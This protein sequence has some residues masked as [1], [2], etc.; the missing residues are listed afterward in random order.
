MNS[1]LIYSLDHTYGNF[2]EYHAGDNPAD[3][4]HKA[5]EMGDVNQMA[6]ILARDPE[7][8]NRLHSVHGTSPLC[9]AIGNYRDPTALDFLIRYQADPLTALNTAS[10]HY[11]LAFLTLVQK[12]LQTPLHQLLLNYVEGWIGLLLPQM[13]SLSTNFLIAIYHNVLLLI[14]HDIRNDYLFESLP[15]LKEL[16]MQRD[17]TSDQREVISLS[18]MLAETAHLPFDFSGLSNDSC[19]S[20]INQFSAHIKDDEL[21]CELVLYANR[22]MEDEDQSFDLSPYY[23]LALKLMNGSN[24][25]FKASIHLNKSIYHATC[26]HLSESDSDSLDMDSGSDDEKSTDELL[27]NH[28]NFNIQR[29]I[30]ILNSLAFKN[31]TLAML[32]RTTVA[33]TFRLLVENTRDIE[34]ILELLKL[35]QNFEM[36]RFALQEIQ[37]ITAMFKAKNALLNDDQTELG[38]HLNHIIYLQRSLSDIDRPLAAFHSDIMEAAL[39]VIGQEI[40]GMLAMQVFVENIHNEVFNALNNFV[41]CVVIMDYYDL[42]AFPILDYLSK[43]SL[44]FKTLYYFKNEILTN[45][46]ALIMY[47]SYFDQALQH[48]S[49]STKKY[50]T[51]LAMITAAFNIFKSQSMDQH[52]PRYEAALINALRASDYSLFTA[53]LQEIIPMLAND[54]DSS[55]MSPL[56]NTLAEHF[57]RFRKTPSKL[58]IELF[59]NNFIVARDIVTHPWLASIYY[60][61]IEKVIAEQAAAARMPENSSN[62]LC[63]LIAENLSTRMD[64]ILIPQGERSLF[65]RYCMFTQNNPQLFQSQPTVPPQVEASTNSSLRPS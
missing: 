12:E 15:R 3:A 29:A 57:D 38:I 28:I 6:I 34:Q 41:L 58:F 40:I 31:N 2:T 9:W 36:E 10:Y 25:A 62:L 20:L 35:S 44:G 64:S 11:P 51:L 23:E 21:S 16:I 13:N 65:S 63:R 49:Y 18:F 56:V 52:F 46:Q 53:G 59:F 14:G 30:D 39:E 48:L 8:L 54:N 47:H 7:S 17:L 42:I 4:M 5:A 55:A 32:L 60:H 37:L 50:T 45:S 22:V 19:L 1:R 33:K 43:D 26:E 24:E 61:A 27:D